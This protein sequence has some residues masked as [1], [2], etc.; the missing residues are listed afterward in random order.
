MFYDPAKTRFFK[1]TLLKVIG[2]A[3][4]AANLQLE[5]NEIQQARGLIRFYKLLPTLGEDIYGFVEWQLLAF[6]Q[7]PLARFN[8]TLLRNQ[9]LDARAITEY[10]HREECSLAWI[11][12]HAYQSEVVPTDDH[13]W[14]FRDGTELA[15]AL[16]DA[17]KL[18]FGYGMPYLEM[19]QD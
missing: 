6:E 18:L 12:R 10:A 3:M 8:V 9:G 13:W 4:T 14:T 2:Q 5:D 7:S 1:D 11:I 17:G 16:V 15:N 19:R